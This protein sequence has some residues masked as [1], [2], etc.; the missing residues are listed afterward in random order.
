MPIYIFISHELLVKFYQHVD[1]L[2]LNILLKIKYGK[3]G[4][5]QNMDSTAT[6]GIQYK[7]WYYLSNRCQIT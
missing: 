7:Q 6:E 3:K 2:L 5:E 1:N 4:I